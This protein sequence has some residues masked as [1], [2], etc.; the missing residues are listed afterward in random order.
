MFLHHDCGSSARV[1]KVVLVIGLSFFLSF[2]MC[3]IRTYS[4]R[5]CEVLSV[6]CWSNVG[7]EG[8]LHYT[9]NIISFIHNTS[10]VTRDILLGGCYLIM[11]MLS[12]VC[13][14]VRVRVRVSVRVRIISKA[15]SLLILSVASLF[16]SHAI[17]RKYNIYLICFRAWCLRVCLLNAA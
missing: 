17:R 16:F 11:R 12:S 6:A 10:G 4:R 14:G 5:V 7:G 3:Y 13:F 8:D 15:R 9:L 2:G 1:D